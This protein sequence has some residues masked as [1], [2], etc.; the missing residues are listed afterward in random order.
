MGN[1]KEKLL[2]DGTIPITF[3]VA[4]NRLNWT[5]YPIHLYSIRINQ[6]F[7]LITHIKISR[8]LP[9]KLEKVV[10]VVNLDHY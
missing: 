1:T 2:L 7:E 8:Y 3:Q 5:L 10:H 6:T 9:W 4:H